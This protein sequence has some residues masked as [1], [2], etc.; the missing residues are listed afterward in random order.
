MIF[1]G[2]GNHRMHGY[3]VRRSTEVARLFV[4]HGYGS[5]N[6]KRAHPPPPPDICHFVVKKPQIPH[7]GAGWFIKKKKKTAVEL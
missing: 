7:S 1:K 3:F 2:R 6:S 5:V 4:S